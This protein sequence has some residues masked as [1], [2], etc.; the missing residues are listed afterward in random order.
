MKQT[1]MRIEKADVPIILLSGLGGFVL[2]FL[3]LA[4]KNLGAAVFVGLVAGVPCGI[5][6]GALAC[7]FR[8][9]LA[10]K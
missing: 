10:R 8:R 7:M 3:A 2:V 1:T 5:G 9:Y 4:A 6:G